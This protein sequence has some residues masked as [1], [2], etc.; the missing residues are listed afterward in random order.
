MNN[1]V[2]RF[3]LFFWEW[4]LVHDYLFAKPPYCQPVVVMITDEGS[5]GPKEE[6]TWLHWLHGPIPM[7]LYVVVPF[8]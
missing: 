2:C 4:L 1:L 3:P 6:R 8:Q 7:M 5:L